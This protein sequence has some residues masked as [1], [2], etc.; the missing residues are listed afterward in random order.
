MLTGRA[1][2][3]RRGGRAVVGLQR[4][5]Q[6]GRLARQVRVR[7]DAVRAHAAVAVLAQHQPGRRAPELH[8]HMVYSPSS[9]VT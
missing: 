8:T 4:A 3:V 9:T 1:V 7:G 5:A 2:E 6:V